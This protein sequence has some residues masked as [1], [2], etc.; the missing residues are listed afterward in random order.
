MDKT[1]FNRR[2]FLGRTGAAAL[3][4]TLGGALPSLAAAGESKPVRIGFIG[5]GGRG[6]VLL[7]LALMMEGVEVP[8]ICD[9]APDHAGRA[10]RLVERRGYKTPELYTRGPEDY[11]RLLERKD[12]DA[13]ICGTPREWHTPMMVEAMKAGI[14]AGTEVPAGVTVDECWQ[15]VETSEKT[16]VP[17]MMLENYCYFRNVMLILNMLDLGLFGDMVHGEVGYQKDERFLRIEP[18][19]ALDGDARLRRDTNGNLYPTHAV[20]PAAWS[21]KVN[22]GDRFDFIVSV[23][24]RSQNLHEYLVEKFGPESAAAKIEFANGDVNTSIIRTVKGRT[25]TVYF[26]TQ[27]ARP[28]DPILRFQSSKG[29]FMGSFEKIYVEGLSPENRIWEDA[30]PYYEKYEHPL[31]KKYGGQDIQLG[32]GV[33]EYL[34]TQQ[35]IEAVRRKAETPLNVYDAAA[36][37]SILELSRQSVAQGSQPV[38]FPDFTRGKWETPRERIYYEV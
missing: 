37:S 27:S 9:I 17:C 8:A 38:K 25:I 34:V 23:S 6:T 19:G 26:D 29:V 20:G 15:L 1:L 4:L 5:V 32:R 14:Y 2:A 7:R 30:A 24:S 13:V 22:R 12:L 11:R 16:G 10:A 21:M 33:C 18:D 3:G 36:W 28:W 31:W 35:F